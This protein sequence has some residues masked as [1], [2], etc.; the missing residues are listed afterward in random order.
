M[1]GF[2]AAPLLFPGKKPDE[3]VGDAL[4]LYPFGEWSVAKKPGLEGLRLGCGELPE[5]ILVD[6][7]DLVQFAA[8]NSVFIS[9]RTFSRHLYFCTV[10]LRR[11]L[12]PNFLAMSCMETLS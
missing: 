6:Q 9:A 4:G 3:P 8:H 7:L 10:A 2:E 11:P 1:D 12:K 5:Q